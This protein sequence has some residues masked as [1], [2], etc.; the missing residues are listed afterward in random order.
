MNMGSS[1]KNICVYGFYNKYNL[2][3]NFFIEAFTHLFPNYTFDFVDRLTASTLNKS[4][5]VFIGGG[6]FLNI[7]PEI[8]KDAIDLLKAK[9]ICYLS[10]GGETDI[11]PEHLELLKLAK[12]IVIRNSEY[13]KKF[14]E[15]NDNICHYPDFV[16]SLQHL[17]P[18][19]KLPNEKIS[20]AILSNINVVPNY[21]SESWQSSSWDYFKSE[22]AQSIDELISKYKI[23]FLP[24]STNASVNDINA[25]IEIINRARYR[26]KFTINDNIGET[27]AE[28]AS[29]LNN[30]DLIITQR[31][32]GIV[33]AEMLNIPYVSIH[34][35]D[36]LK[37]HYPYNGNYLSYYNFNKSSLLESIDILLNIDKN[38]LKISINSNSFKGL[39][40]KVEMAL[41]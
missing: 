2:G 36:K 34:H 21:N 29:N 35:H 1:L 6:S 12:L 38:K 10:V 32:H 24:F 3:D 30:Y 22:F 4:E 17:L 20:I 40:E 5:A 26:S 33:L 41:N 37:P 9:K 7:K 14:K 13:I 16:Y 11:H 39:K 28:I 31:Y 23:T 18:K 19:E 8:D 15:V 25:S 27:F